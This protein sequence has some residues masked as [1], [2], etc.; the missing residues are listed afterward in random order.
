MAHSICLSAQKLDIFPSCWVKSEIGVFHEK[1]RYWGSR[2]PVLWSVCVFVVTSSVRGLWRT[3]CYHSFSLA[4]YF[5][6][7]FFR[8]EKF[9]TVLPLPKF[10][11]LVF[12]SCPCTGPKGTHWLALKQTPGFAFRLCPSGRLSCHFGSR[13]WLWSFLAV[14][15]PQH[16]LIL[17]TPRAREKVTS[18][19]LKT[20]YTATSIRAGIASMTP[21]LLPTYHPQFQTSHPNDGVGS[22]NRKVKPHPFNGKL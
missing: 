17:P 6:F 16:L 7:F 12:P 22:W 4:V 5:R 14:R 20:N 13:Q 18:A 21:T 19:F 2:W 1:G 11:I 10:K 3:S 8:I 15:R 9:I